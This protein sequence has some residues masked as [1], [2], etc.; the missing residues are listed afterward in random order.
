MN[1]GIFTSDTIAWLGT[2]IPNIGTP[3]FAVD[4]RDNRE[5]EVIPVAAAVAGLEIVAV[6]GNNRAVG[7]V[8]EGA[9]DCK[10]L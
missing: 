4:L 7:Q 6:H 3:Q 9:A 8:T 1:Q 10:M 2:E 5:R